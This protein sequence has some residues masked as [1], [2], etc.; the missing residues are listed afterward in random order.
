MGRRQTKQ[1]Y[2]V[3]VRFRQR[4]GLLTEEQATMFEGMFRRCRTP[5][6]FAQVS[7][8]VNDFING[9]KT[10]TDRHALIWQEDPLGLDEYEEKHFGD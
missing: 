9:I 7:Q 4:A 3:S 6:E 5:A 10:A 8:V 1:R 2:I